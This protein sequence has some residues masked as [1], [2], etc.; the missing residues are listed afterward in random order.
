MKPHLDDR[1]DIQ[2]TKSL[3]IIRASQDSRDLQ[4][5][6]DH[7]KLHQQEL[8]ETLTNHGAIASYMRSLPELQ[9]TR[10]LNPHA[11]APSKKPG[12]CDNFCSPTEI[13][14]RNP[15]SEFSRDRISIV[16]DICL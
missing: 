11:I 13:S 9:E 10:F 15:V 7:L 8:K 6:L 3:P 12:F 2:L 4:S 5:L 14:Q 16:R 1:Q